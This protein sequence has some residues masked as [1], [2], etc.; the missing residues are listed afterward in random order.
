[1]NVLQFTI[2][3]FTCIILYNCMFF[4][5]FFTGFSITE[6]GISQLEEYVS[7]NSVPDSSSEFTSISISIVNITFLYDLN[8]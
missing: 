4:L 8:D 2:Y 6:T 1:M 7:T 5:L 3:F